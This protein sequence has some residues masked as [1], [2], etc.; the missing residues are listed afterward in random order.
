MPLVLIL[1]VSNGVSTVFINGKPNFINGQGHLQRHPPNC[2]ILEID[3]FDNFKLADELF[4]K[5]IQIVKTC[6]SVSNNLCWN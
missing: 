6:L 1:L 4:T 5:L 3:V 2:V